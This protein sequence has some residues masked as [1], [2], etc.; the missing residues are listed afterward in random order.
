MGTKAEIQKRWNEKN[1]DKVKEI[2]RRSYEKRKEQQAAL[3]KKW[4]EENRDK[5]LEGHRK[6]RARPEYKERENARQL[7]SRRD[8]PFKFS[9]QQAR[10]RAR[11]EGW[12][13]NVDIEYLKSIWTGV[14]PITGVELQIGQ[15][16][17]TIPD[18]YRASLDRLDSTKG[19]VKGNVQYISFRANNIKTDSSFE[20]FEQI[21]FWWKGRLQN[22][23]VERIDEE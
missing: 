18:T 21:Y 17:D 11:S 6:S 20:E 7:Q 10:R 16:K 22:G 2:Q 14:C 3:G 15:A 19:Y 5:Y 9:A 8:N 13:C 4:R 23:N 12:E 1:P